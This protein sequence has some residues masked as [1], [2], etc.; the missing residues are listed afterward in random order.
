MRRIITAFV[1]LLA[2][3]AAVSAQGLFPSVWQTQRGAVLKVLWVDAALAISPEF[4]SVAQQDHVQ[5]FLIGWLEAF[6]ALG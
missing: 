4:S 5:A 3:A 1:I 2:S 6:G